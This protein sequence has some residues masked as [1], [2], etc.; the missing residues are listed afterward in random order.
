[1]NTRR[2]RV[3]TIDAICASELKTISDALKRLRFVGCKFEDLRWIVKQ[4]LDDLE[5]EEKEAKG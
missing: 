4:M 3:D 5:K 2:K 1:M